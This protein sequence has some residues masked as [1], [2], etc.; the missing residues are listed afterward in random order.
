M[1][2]MMHRLRV[3]ETTYCDVGWEVLLS[4]DTSVMR[5]IEAPANDDQQHKQDHGVE[6][7]R[8]TFESTEPLSLTALKEMVKR[9]LPAEVYRLKGFVHTADD[10]EHRYV[11]HTVGRRS[12][13]RRHGR[14]GDTIPMTRL[15]AIGAADKLDQAWLSDALGQCTRPTANSST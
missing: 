4:T 7:D 8:W 14:W 1:D 11:V 5:L 12:E 2:Q 9:R 10:P 13:I 3:V 15:V 6:F